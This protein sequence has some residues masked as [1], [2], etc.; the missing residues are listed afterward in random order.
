MVQ[1]KPLAAR[2]PPNPVVPRPSAA[3]FRRREVD[4]LV[5]GKLGTLREQIGELEPS[6]PVGVGG[7]L[8]ALLDRIEAIEAAKVT[9]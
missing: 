8:H 1:V 7:I 6:L 3:S 9:R 5:H 4:R 2:I